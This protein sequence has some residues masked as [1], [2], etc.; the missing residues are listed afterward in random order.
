MFR[1][2]LDTKKKIR[3]WLWGLISFVFLSVTLLYIFIS[4]EMFGPMPTFEELE[5]PKSNL[6]SEVISEDHK[7]L[8]T[9]FVQN[10]TFVGYDKIS[11]NLVKA[12]L[13]TEDIRFYQHSGIDARGLG[14]VFIKTLLLGNR[15]AGGGSTITQQLAKNLFPRD[16]IYHSF[17]ISKL[18]HLSIAKFK[19]W[20]TAV[21][22]E[23][24]YTKDE[25]LAMYLNIVEFGGNSYGIKSAAKTFFNTTPDSIKVEQAAVLI[26]LV[27]APSRYSPVR[28]PERS[29]ERRNFVLSQMYK[30]EFLTK[31]KY[32]S[33]VR[34][35]IR[36]TYRVQDHNVGLGT[37]FRETLRLILIAKKP[38]AK[39]YFT[40][41]QFVED[42]L[43]WADNPLYGWCNKNL[44]PDGT[45]YS[46]YRDG[47]KIYT[48][49]NSRM[50]QYAEEAVEEHLSKYLQLQF[51]YEQKRSGYRLFDSKLTNEQVKSIL[52]HAMKQTDRYRILRSKGVSMENI[53][54]NFNTK[55]RMTIFTW[56]GEKDT[57]MT[58]MD[59]IKHYKRFFRASFMAMNPH[60]GFIKAYVG[61]PNYKH[62]KYDQ[63][64]QGKRQVGSTIKPFLYT[65]AMQ[66]GY[67]PCYKVPN[68]SQ[69]FI[70]KMRNKDGELKD[71][72]WTPKNSGSTKYDGKMVTLKWGLANSVNNISAWLIKQFTPQAVADIIKKMGI[73]SK[74]QAVHSV[75]L[76]TSEVSLYEMVGAYS[77]F[78][79]KGVHVEPLMVTKIEDKN[80]NVLASFTP[81]KSEAISEQTAYLM[82]NLL[83]GVINSGTGVRL[84]LTY[85]LLGPIAGK[86]GTTQNHS[87][88]WFMG[89]LPNLVTGT[90]VGAEDRSVHFQELYFGQGATMALPIYALF[91]Q[92][93]YKD[94]RLGISPNDQW[95]KPLVTKYFDTDC[96][97]AKGKKKVKKE[98]NED[99][100]F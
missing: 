55:T 65:L 53:Y 9:Y 3:W 44:K 78:A 66:E 30:Y 16:T 31:H 62:F 4:I 14:R 43:Q 64:L 80:G 88:G 90:W 18:A 84:R 75:F 58:P 83:E 36:L 76:G 32:D 5:N 50:Q 95:E 67:S 42:S 92:K 91:L 37:Y 57:L 15:E 48:T 47:L 29:L 10:R 26:G 73:S 21:K 70:E 59:S 24:N 8:G 7:V 19:E 99:D 89:M 17:F 87:D 25:I 12:L 52:L 51:D 85:E 68:V 27:N 77:T 46:I 63:V 33:L 45:P 61:G 38:D 40:H 41:E 69:T 86:T 82:I 28:N 13:A 94:S 72:T 60:T 98:V 22:L 54:T 1:E 74:I 6:A 49:I 93:V 20:I 97:E 71:S 100:F 79:N 34:I 35:P 2:K 56:K 81:Q 23:K 39:F 11:P 96:E